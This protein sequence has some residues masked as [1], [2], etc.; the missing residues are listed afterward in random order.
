MPGDDDFHF[1]GSF[2]RIGGWVC[3]SAAKYFL[4]RY[5]L[6]FVKVVLRTIT[7]GADAQA[8]QKG[9]KPPASFAFER[10]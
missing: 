5:V 6:C 3:H 8:S 9:I 2:S 7:R 4:R 10:I 1:F